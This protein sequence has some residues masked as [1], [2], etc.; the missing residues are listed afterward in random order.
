M[1]ILTYVTNHHATN[2]LRNIKEALEAK[3]PQAYGWEFDFCRTEEE[4]IS[5]LNETHPRIAKAEIMLMDTMY[6]KEHGGFKGLTRVKNAHPTYTPPLLVIGLR[7]HPEEIAYLKER[8]VDTECL[9]LENE[10]HAQAAARIAGKIRHL[11][12]REGMISTKDGKLTLNLE[13]GSI[14][15]KDGDFYLPKGAETTSRIIERV[16][17]NEVS[18][19]YPAKRLRLKYANASNIHLGVAKQFITSLTGG[20]LALSQVGSRLVFEDNT[21]S[22]TTS[23]TSQPQAFR[24]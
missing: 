23:P 8:K 17:R 4:L 11:A 6:F 14:Q 19:G 16:I 20:G 12:G 22:E 1:R 7:E 21:M 5:S 2:A 10:T 9:A 18:G 3:R 15:Y 24:I 13:N